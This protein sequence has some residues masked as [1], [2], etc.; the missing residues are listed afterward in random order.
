M[1]LGIIGLSMP[2]YTPCSITFDSIEE[3]PNIV[4]NMNVTAVYECGLRFIET[5]KEHNEREWL[6]IIR[7][8]QHRD[9]SKSYDAFLQSLHRNSTY[10]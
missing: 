6:Q 4:L 7:S 5:M 1:S 3:I 10:L 2:F 8:I 9:M